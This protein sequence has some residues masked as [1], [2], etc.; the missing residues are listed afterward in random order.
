MESSESAR[1][2]ATGFEVNTK[3]RPI[4]HGRRPVWV[5]AG[6]A[7]EISNRISP[8]SLL[9]E[10]GGKVHPRT[11][12]DRVGPLVSLAGDRPDPSHCKID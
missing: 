7:G 3:A 12:S 9:R 6:L 5:C 10:P 1:R 4:R 2:R 8:S 11:V